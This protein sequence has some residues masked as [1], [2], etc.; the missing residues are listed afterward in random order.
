MMRESF[1]QETIS[2]C[3]GQCTITRAVVSERNKYADI[4]ENKQI[5]VNICEI[6]RI[7]NW[8]EPEFRGANTVSILQ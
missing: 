5:D 2:S 1:K 8:Y 7:R 4:D 3:T 6:R